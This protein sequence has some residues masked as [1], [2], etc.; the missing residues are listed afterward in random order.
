[1]MVRN[2]S[3]KAVIVNSLHLSVVRLAS[4]VRETLSPSMTEN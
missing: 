3:N 1:M 4:A 2:V